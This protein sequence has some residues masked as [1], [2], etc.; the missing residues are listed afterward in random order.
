MVHQPVESI[1][2]RSWRLLNG[3]W[4]IVVPGLVIGLA[5]SLLTALM[6]I[7]LPRSASEAPGLVVGGGFASIVWLAATV[8][9]VAYT[10][11]MA[12]AAW[13]NGT[14]TF[15]DGAQAL[16][17]NWVNVVL[18][19]ICVTFFGVIA[20]FLSLPTLGLSLLAFTL[21]FMY[22]MPSTILGHRSAAAAIGDSWQT[23]THHFVQTMLILLVI[24]AVAFALLLPTVFL[25]I[26]PFFGPLLSATLVQGAC[27]FFTLMVV[28]EYI[29]AEHA[30]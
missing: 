22:T 13:R 5:A 17:E 2:V 3:N 11:G 9:S 24:V 12:G 7:G 25:G 16:K 14:T 1:V 26:V 18:A 8:I 4:A 23:V 15:T 29:D 27:A 19:M 6:G 21:F 10:T 20:A 28:G 30:V